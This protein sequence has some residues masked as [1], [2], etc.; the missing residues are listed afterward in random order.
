MARATADQRAALGR[1]APRIIFLHG[2]GQNA[3]TWDTVIVGL[4]E[5]ALAVD[6]P[7]HGHS[8]WRE[9]G[10]YSPQNNAAALAPVLQRSRTGGRPRGGHVVGRADRDT[11]G[12]GRTR[13]GGRTR[14]RRRHP[15]GAAA[16]RRADRRTAGHGGADA[17]RA[18][19]PQLPG[20]A[21]PDHRRGA[22]PRGEG[23]APRRV[24][25]LPPAR[26]RQLDVALRRHPQGPRLRRSVGRRRRALRADHPDPRR[27][28]G[29]RHRRGRRRTQPGAQSISARPMSWRIRATRCK[30]TSRA[31]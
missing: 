4:G 8:G 24:P 7:G 20:H 28:V 16:A 26:Q 21:G 14:P 12:R 19:V 5:P 15:L 17:G 25:Q 2:G 22:A 29:L 11:A 1:H 31:R 23:A 9:D 10:D 3:H 6:L 30:A 27:H 13:P 18:G